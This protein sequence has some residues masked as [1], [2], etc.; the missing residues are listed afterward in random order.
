MKREEKDEERKKALED[1]N[2][3][4]IMIDRFIQDQT[5]L[6]MFQLLN[7]LTDCQVAIPV[8]MRIPEEVQNQMKSAKIG[9]EISLKSDMGFTPDNLIMP[10]GKR[11]LP[12]FSKEE[13]EE[14]QRNQKPCKMCILHIYK[15]FFAS[16]A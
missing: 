15:S 16:N 10:D 13:K 8:N 14:D 6:K 4:G 11:F 1:G 12:I 3:L 5:G 7:C 2:V 9:D